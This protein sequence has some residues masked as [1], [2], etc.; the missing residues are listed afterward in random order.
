[1]PADGAA[2]YGTV[3]FGASAGD[4]GSG[5]ARVEFRADGDLFHTVFGGYMYIA[6][7]DASG[8]APGPHVIQVT[9]YDNA[10]NSASTSITVYVLDETPPAVSLT[11]PDDQAV[12]WGSVAIGANATDA[13]SGVERVEFAVDGVTIATDPT[14]PYSAVWDATSATAGEHTITA[15]AYDGAGNS[16][17]AS[18]TVTVAATAPTRSLIGKKYGDAVLDTY[19]YAWRPTTIYNTLSTMVVGR[20]SYGEMRALMSF[21]LAKLAGPDVGSAVLHLSRSS[22]STSVPLRAYRLK[23]TDIEWPW[24]TWNLYK[25]GTPWSSPGASGAGADYWADVYCDSPSLTDLDVTA[26]ARAAVAAGEPSLDLLIVDPV[27]V[28]G[29]YVSLYSSEY[30]LADFKPWLEVTSAPGAGM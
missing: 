20:T 30:P 16:A 19:L 5:I 26:L 7:W 6:D 25:P 8:A 11:S 24:A 10:G 4:T 3:W 13:E 9:A 17:V 18:R 15:T 28:S 21:P 27:P 22:G 1:M 14:A 29:R 2:V 12:V 23:R